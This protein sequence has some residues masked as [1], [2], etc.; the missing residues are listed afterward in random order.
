MER[1]NSKLES[2]LPIR[3]DAGRRPHVPLPNLGL[4]S[5]YLSSSNFRKE[6]FFLKLSPKDY[7]YPAIQVFSCLTAFGHDTTSDGI[8]R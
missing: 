6:L 4:V 3:E 7:G 1:H 8:H 5:T 2:L